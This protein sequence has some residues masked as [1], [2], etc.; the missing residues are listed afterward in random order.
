MTSGVYLLGFNNTH[1]VY[2]GQSNNVEYRYT[3]HMKEFNANKHSI[4]LQKAFNTYGV[5]SVEI[6]EECSNDINAKEN[7]Y[8]SL[9]NSV[10]DGFNTLKEAGTWP[11]KPGDTNPQSKYS[12]E[13]IELAFMLLVHYRD[14]SIQNVADESGVSNGMIKMISRG[15]SHIWLK[16]K[17][18]EE[19]AIL[20]NTKNN[21]SRESIYKHTGYPPLISPEG[22]IYTNITNVKKFCEEHNLTQ[23][24]VSALYLGKQSHHKGWKI[25][26]I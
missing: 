14:M 4:K 17:Y 11:I 23:V 5:P 7:Y 13:Q 21:S 3:Q 1:K 22:T 24:R 9:Y 6:L 20:I 25:Y 10:D 16:D 26:K 2:I 8:I 19:Y 12:N 15:V 18:P